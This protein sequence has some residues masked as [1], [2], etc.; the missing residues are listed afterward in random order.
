MHDASGETRPEYTDGVS[1]S[2]SAF[3]SSL[4]IAHTHMKS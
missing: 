4:L 3:D 1:V 2:I